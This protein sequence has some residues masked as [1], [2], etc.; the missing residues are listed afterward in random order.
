MEIQGFKYSTEAEAQEA[1]EDINE[2]YNIPISAEATTRTWTDYKAEGDFFYIR[3]HENIKE[4]GGGGG[5]RTIT[6]NLPE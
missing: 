2:H 1:I 4:G 3:S 6:E 5:R